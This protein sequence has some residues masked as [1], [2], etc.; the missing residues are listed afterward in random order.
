MRVEPVS[1]YSKHI[2][3]FWAERLCL[4]SVQKTKCDARHGNRL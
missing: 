1:H 4:P 2:G 3:W